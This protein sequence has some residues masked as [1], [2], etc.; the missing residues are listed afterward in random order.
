M[1]F[2]NLQYK[3][4][5]TTTLRIT[6]V[7]YSVLIQ[8]NTLGDFKC[9]ERYKESNRGQ[10]GALKAVNNYTCTKTSLVSV[11]KFLALLEPVALTAPLKVSKSIAYLLYITKQKWKAHYKDVEAPTALKRSWSRTSV[12]RKSNFLRNRSNL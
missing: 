3:L 9:C 1:G 7:S 5:K 2:K 12:K 11:V 8:S 10:Q 4:F 6:I